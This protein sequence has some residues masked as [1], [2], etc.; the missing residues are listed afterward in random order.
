QGQPFRLWEIDPLWHPVLSAGQLGERFAETV[1]HHG[2]ERQ[3]MGSMLARAVL[4]AAQ[5]LANAQ[6]FP[7]HPRHMHHTQW[8]GPLQL[9]RL[10]RRRQFWGY[11][12]PT[13]ADPANAAGQPEQGCAIEG[14]SPAEVVDDVGRRPALGWIPAGLRQLVIL[15]DRSVLV[16][17][18]GH[19]QVHA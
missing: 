4:E 8:A 19:A 13:V 1:G 7:Q 11:L 6:L 2:E 14:I 16:V 17:A 3:L 12:E 15:D 18:S 9:D 10:T 5:D